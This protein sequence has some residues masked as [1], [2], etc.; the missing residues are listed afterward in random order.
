M[1]VTETSPYCF[2]NSNFQGIFGEMSTYCGKAFTFIM[3][4]MP[5]KKAS[6]FVRVFIF[7]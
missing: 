6:F 3:F 5:N 1:H 2:P 4:I 7:F